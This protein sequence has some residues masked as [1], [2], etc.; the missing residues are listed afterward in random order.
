MKLRFQ[1]DE[2]RERMVADRIDSE[3][4]SKLQETKAILVPKQ[5]EMLHSTMS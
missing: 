2:I 4:V 3:T 1:S 5:R